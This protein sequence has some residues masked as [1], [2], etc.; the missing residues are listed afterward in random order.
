MY[1]PSGGIFD[2]TASEDI[3]MFGIGIK[4]RIAHLRNPDYFEQSHEFISERWK[5]EKANKY[6]Q[7]IGL[8]SSGGP[9]GCI[10]KYLAL[11]ESRVMMI[12]VP[13]AVRQP[14]GAVIK[15]R[16]YRMLLTVDLPNSKVVLNRSA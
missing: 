12:K 3:E 4:K 10:G 15:E 13:E 9:R 2:R 14:C 5:K 8:T 7:L 1:S 6:Q 11:T 16:A